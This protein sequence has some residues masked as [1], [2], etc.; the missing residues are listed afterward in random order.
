ML[1]QLG[2]TTDVALV[3]VRCYQESERS[4]SIEGT[5]TA[6]GQGTSLLYTPGLGRYCLPAS[7]QGDPMA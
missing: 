5:D 6:T 7:F 2:G 3:T 4:L 1:Q